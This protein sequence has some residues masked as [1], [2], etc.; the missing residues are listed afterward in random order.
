MPVV[1]TSPM[2]HSLPHISI[3]L[4][5][6]PI[7]IPKR[8]TNK[9][10]K[11]VYNQLIKNNQQYME[12][13]VLSSK[14]MLPFC[15]LPQKNGTTTPTPQPDPYGSSVGGTT[16]RCR[17]RRWS[18]PAEPAPPVPRLRG[19][20]HRSEDGHVHVFELRGQQQKAASEPLTR[21]DSAR[22]DAFGPRSKCS[23]TSLLS[24][25]SL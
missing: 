21:R 25:G 11:K 15:P 22:P 3:I 12:S 8:Q 4:I 2:N 24:G 19:R 13:K 18:P 23:A 20:L 10:N 14:K 5:L 6:S 1:A 17:N 16:V 7:S 9:T